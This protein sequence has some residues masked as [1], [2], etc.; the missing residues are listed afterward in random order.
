MARYSDAPP[1]SDV[2]K[3]AEQRANSS[4][5]SREQEND[6]RTAPSDIN[7]A[8]AMAAQS[9]FSRAAADPKKAA[10]LWSATRAAVGGHGSS[11]EGYHH[12]L[13]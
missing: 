10:A 11:G 7:A 12:T 6:V 9:G 3:S 13:P 8:F 1:C 4:R 2:E 5:Q